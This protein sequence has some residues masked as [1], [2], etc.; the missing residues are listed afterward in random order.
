MKV[1]RRFTLVELLFVIAIITILACLLLPALS[2]AK[3]MARRIKCTENQKQLSLASIIY[4][5]DYN[6]YFPPSTGNWAYPNCLN[7][8]GNT[9]GPAL[10]E[11]IKNGN[12]LLCPGNIRWPRTYADMIFTTYNTNYLFYAARPAF[13]SSPVRLGDKPGWLLWGDIYGFLKST[14]GPYP[15]NHEKGANWTYLDGHLA[16]MN[17]TSL[18]KVHSGLDIDFYYPPTN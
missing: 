18:T 8:S 12:L 11:Y 1:C 7:M 10:K 2:S 9:Q 5:Q 17:N 6:G 14:S 16:W 4:A 3:E 15:R 13:P